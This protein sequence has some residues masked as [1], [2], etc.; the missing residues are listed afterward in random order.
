[1]IKKQSIRSGTIIKLNGVILE[2][3]EVIE[4]SKEWTKSQEVVF[5]RILSQGGRMEI[6]TGTI[7]ISK[8]LEIWKR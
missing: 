4:L 2:K 6:E 5:R 7:T 1:M 3:D 8:E